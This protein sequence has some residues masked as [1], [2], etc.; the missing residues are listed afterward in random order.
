MARSLAK[1]RKPAN[2]FYRSAKVS[3]YQFKRV[4]WSFVLDE[5]VAAAA[6]RINLSANS[7]NAIY[8][9]LR[10]FFTEAGTF[11]DI[12]EGGDPT[13]GYRD[14]DADDEAFEFGLLSFHLARRKAKRRMGDTQLQEVDYSWCESHWRFV[15]SAMTDG[16][17]D[18]NV[19][20]MLYSQLLAVIRLCGPVGAPARRVEDGK[21]LSQHHF[22]QRLLWME[23]NLPNWRDEAKRQRVRNYRARNATKYDKI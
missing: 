5:S 11:E 22:N 17:A 23:R 20:R 21:E 13:D 3:E 4:L 7:I 2:R 9:K 16:R 18:E 19:P 6:K 1:S 8:T 10:R 15:C 12:Y 14:G